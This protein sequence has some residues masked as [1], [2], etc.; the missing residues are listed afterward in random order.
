MARKRLEIAR[1][2]EDAAFDALFRLPRGKRG[3]S[4]Q[5]WRMNKTRKALRAIERRKD[6]IA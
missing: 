1:E 5:E 4:K 2:R 3:G 6:R